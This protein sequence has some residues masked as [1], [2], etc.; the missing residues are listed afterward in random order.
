[1]HYKGD[2]SKVDP[3]TV[4]IDVQGGYGDSVYGGGAGDPGADF[5]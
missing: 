4:K 1:M 5:K 3:N 2:L